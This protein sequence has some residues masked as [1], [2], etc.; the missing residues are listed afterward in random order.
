VT[1]GYYLADVQDHDAM[2]DSWLRTG[3]I[4]MIHKDGY[5]YVTGRNKVSHFLGPSTL[6]S[7]KAPTQDLVKYNGAQIIPHELE[8]VLLSHPFVLDTGVM[9]L[10]L[11][12]GNELPTVFLVLKETVTSTS[13]TTTEDIAG[14]TDSRVRPYKRLRGGAYAVDAIPKNAV[15]KIQYRELRERAK[16]RVVSGRNRRK[17]QFKL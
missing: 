4:G 9:G 1:S 10:E 6:Q 13:E 16:K 5:V 14:F 2:Q 8:A 11:P 7:T 12:D 3:D 15:G 17:G